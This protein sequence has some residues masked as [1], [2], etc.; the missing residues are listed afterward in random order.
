MHQYSS[1]RSYFMSIIEAM[2]GTNKL[3][4]NSY[5]AAF[6]LSL[7]LL[8]YLSAMAGI[9]PGVS[10]K[11]CHCSITIFDMFDYSEVACIRELQL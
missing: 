9:L 4:S 5:F 11:Q 10:K 7:L 1:S 6:I 2:S 3:K 8:F